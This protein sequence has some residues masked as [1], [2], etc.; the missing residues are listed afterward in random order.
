MARVHITY[1]RT[2]D[3]FIGATTIHT[4][5]GSFPILAIVPLRPFEVRVFEL[6]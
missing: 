2:Q 4:A 1:D 5:I 6:H 3:A